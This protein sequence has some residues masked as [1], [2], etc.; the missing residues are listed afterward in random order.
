M[1]QGCWKTHFNLAL[2]EHQKTHEKEQG[3]VSGR[4]LSPHTDTSRAYAWGRGRWAA[5]SDFSLCSLKHRDGPLCSVPLE[6]DNC[7]CLGSLSNVS[8]SFKI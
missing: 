2:A 1:C 8:G 3:Y 4:T 6:K 5:D 7:A